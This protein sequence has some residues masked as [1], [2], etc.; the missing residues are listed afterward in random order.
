VVGFSEPEFGPGDP[1]FFTA[2]RSRE[3]LGLE[4]EDCLH[5]CMC[6]YVRGLCY[7]L[8]SFVKETSLVG[9][10][11]TI[12]HHYVQGL[13]CRPLIDPKGVCTLLNDLVCMDTLQIFIKVGSRCKQLPYPRHVQF[14][15]NNVKLAL[16][17]SIT[18]LVKLEDLPG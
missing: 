9:E 1:S 2:D 7:R 6:V 12:G 11:Q 15:R 5:E 14:A 3:K 4:P 18:Y 10:V 17:T 8:S 16:P 13:P